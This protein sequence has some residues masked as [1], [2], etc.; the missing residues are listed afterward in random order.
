MLKSLFRQNNIFFIIK[1]NKF[2]SINLLFLKQM[3]FLS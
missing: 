1:H 2:I 3:L